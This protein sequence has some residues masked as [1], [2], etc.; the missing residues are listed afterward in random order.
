[1]Y[2][3]NRKK[4][5]IYDYACNFAYTNGERLIKTKMVLFNTRVHHGVHSDMRTGQAT[6]IEDIDGDRRSMFEA[7]EK[8]RQFGY[9]KSTIAALWYKDP[10]ADDSESNLKLL[11]GDSYAIE[12]CNIAELRGF[13]NLFVV[14]E[15]GDADGFSEVGYIDVGG[16]TG[17]FESEEPNGGGLEI[18]VFEGDQKKTDVVGDTEGQIGGGDHESS[19]EYSDDLTYFPSNDEGDSAKDIHFTD[20]EEKYDYDSGFGEE[21]Y[22]P[23]DSI[24]DKGKRVVT[25][26]LEDEEAANSD[27][28]ENDHMIGGHDLVA[29]DAEEDADCE[30]L[31]FPVHKPEKDMRNYNWKVGTLYESRQQ[32]KDIVAAYAV[33][34]TR[35]IKFK[36]CDLFKKKVES[37]PRIKVK[38]LV[39]KAHKKWNLTVTRAIETKTKQEALSQIQG[40]FREQYKRINY[41]CGELL[42]TNPIPS[43]YLKVIRSPYFTQERQNPNLMNYCVFQRLY[44][45][46]DACKKSF[47]HCKP[48]IRLDRCFLKTPQGG[49]LLTAI[50]RDPN[51]QILPIAYAVVE[52]ETKD[53]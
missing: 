31:R 22:V 32:F 37:N 41:Y 24:V 12:M 20:S 27:D 18:V 48:F 7:Y 39:A 6:V 10:N 52:G 26:D 50:G 1:M 28:L 2:D 47:Q 35:T 49:Q 21:N 9:L 44:V 53:S 34:K 45:Y 30:G 23:K 42:R 36:K 19:S 5:W 51:E 43:V 17:S 3:H 8:L 4:V 25:S 11:K 13:V 16:D 14:H 33:Q 46:F 15:V 29:D 40:A 38:D